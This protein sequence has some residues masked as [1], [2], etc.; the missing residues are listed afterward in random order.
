[1][2]IVLA[3]VGRSGKGYVVDSGF[4]VSICLLGMIHQ[5]IN[6]STISRI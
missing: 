6:D 2:S 5:E 1:M 4:R 3:L